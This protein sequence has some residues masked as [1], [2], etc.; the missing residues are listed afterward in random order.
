MVVWMVLIVLLRIE[1][2][3]FSKMISFIY[4][5]VDEISVKLLKQIKLDSEA[6]SSCFTC[7]GSLLAVG[8]NCGD[9]MVWN[10]NN[11]YHSIRISLHNS[12]VEELIFSPTMEPILVSRGEVIAWWNLKTFQ[13]KTLPRTRKKVQSLQIMKN[14][15]I[16]NQ[17]MDI[18][19]W[20]DKKC[21]E[22]ENYLLSCLNLHGRARCLS[23]SKDFNTFLTVDENGKIYVMEAVAFKCD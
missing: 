19:F 6:I 21:L 15:A 16:D 13:Q 7:D 9:I 12:C 5:I 3:P 18:S 11:D 2:L 4:T 22:G 10:L 8:M 23:A 20:S 17:L 1:L 14:T